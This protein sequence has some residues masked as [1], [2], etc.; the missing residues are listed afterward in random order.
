MSAMSSGILPFS[1][2]G[3]NRPIVSG[4]SNRNR[5][6]KG[7]VDPHLSAL[8]DLNIGNGDISWHKNEDNGGWPG[9]GL[10][11]QQP[12]FVQ[13]SR[14]IGSKGKRLLMDTED[15]LELKLTWEEAQD[16]LRPPPTVKP[17]IVKI[18]DHEFEEYEVS[19]KIEVSK[20]FRKHYCY[21]LLC[22]SV[23]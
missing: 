16:L 5:S 19:I 4:Y 11:M 2:A 18:E 14:K 7:Y 17:S 10:P 9:E 3:G 22:H 15:A 12:L 23:G 6:P 13:R 20:Y 1:G 8:S 21:Y